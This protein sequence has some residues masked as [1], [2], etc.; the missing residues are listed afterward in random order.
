MPSLINARSARFNRNCSRLERSAV[1]SFRENT[2]LSQGYNAL[3][4][5]ADTGNE[6]VLEFLLRM[7]ANPTLTNKH[8]HPARHLV[9]S[10]SNIARHLKGYEFIF[11]A[12]NNHLV[13]VKELLRTDGGLI[14]FQG[15]DG[16]TAIMVAA[17]QNHRELVM[18]LLTFQP[19]LEIRSHKG[20]TLFDVCHESLLKYL[21]QQTKLASEDDE[22]TSSEVWPMTKEYEDR[23][24]FFKIHEA[25]SDST[26]PSIEKQSTLSLSFVSQQSEEV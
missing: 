20:E 5:A 14:D 8:G 1:K 19:N 23:H 22:E 21:M 7:G 3:M 4:L 18:Y 25:P 2:E 6:R 16:F 9:A 12:A 10:S 24:N 17:A 13:V 26:K 15:T 11:A